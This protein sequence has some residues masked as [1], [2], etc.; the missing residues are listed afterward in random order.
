MEKEL[1]KIQKNKKRGILSKRKMCDQA[2]E[3][4]LNIKGLQVYSTTV[5]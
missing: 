2:F 4:L 1:C 3:Q 5:I